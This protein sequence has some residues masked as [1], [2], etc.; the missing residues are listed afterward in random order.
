ML[1]TAKPSAGIES[2]GFELPLC[3]KEHEDYKTRIRSFIDEYGSQSQWSC[4][5][6]ELSPSV[7]ARFGWK[8]V[9]EDM[10]CCILCKSHLD[11]Q[12][13]NSLG[14]KLYKQCTEKLVSSL[15]DAHKSCCPWKTAPCPESY[16]VMEPVMRLEALDQLRERL[17]TLVPILSSLPLLSFEQIQKQLGNEAIA[18]ICK[19]AGEEQTKES[20]RAVLLALTGWRTAKVGTWLYASPKELISQDTGCKKENGE[21]HGVKRKHEE[22]QMDPVKEHRPWCIWVVTGTSGKKGWVVYSEC[23][24]RNLESSSDQTGTP[25]SVAAFQEKVERI[26]NSWKKIKVPPT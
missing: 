22:E 3:T 12:L 19:L 11:C 23:L 13:S 24:L 5:P 21:G 17:G 9:G 10:L 6:P 16:A 8:C 25:P 1:S 2:L 15:K 14:H 4:K 26:L 18:K 20:E 7:C